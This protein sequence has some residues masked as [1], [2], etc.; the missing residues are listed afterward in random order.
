MEK[1]SG[2]GFQRTSSAESSLMRPRR[3]SGVAASRSR[4]GMPLSIICI[5]SYDVLAAIDMDGVARH[6]I[7]GGVA[8]GGDAAGHVVRRSEAL[9]GIAQAGDLH[10][11]FMA[12]DEAEGGGIG[13]AGEDGVGGDAGGGEFEGELADV[14]FEDGLGGT[15]RWGLGLGG[16]G[17]GA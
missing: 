5:L 2:A 1:R 17:A 11:L 9:V 13:D 7:G 15:D 10:E 4:Q 3:M 8:E 6:P 12:G 16:G 14:G